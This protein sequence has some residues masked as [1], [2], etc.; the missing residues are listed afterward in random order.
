MNIGSVFSAIAIAGAVLLLGA[1]SS[2]NPTSF[3]STIG[4]ADASPAPA[5]G[6]GA[7]GLSLA[8]IGA[9]LGF[10]SRDLLDCPRAP[11]PYYGVSTFLPAPKIDRSMSLGQI[12]RLMKV[13]D[14]HMALG[15]TESHEVVFALMSVGTQKMPSGGVCAYPTRIAFTLALTARK[16]HVASDFARSEPCVYDAVLTH[17]ERHVALDDQLMRI[18]ANALRLAAPKRFA[19]LYGVWG[20][21]ENAA[22]LNLQRRLE[23]DD[24]DLRVE[25]ERKRVETQADEIDTQAERH[26]LVEACDGRLAKLYPGYM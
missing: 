16:I 10:K 3:G 13:D 24:E 1:C 8:A 9:A 26:H 11:A 19:N 18:A 6:G 12:G 7:R 2:R 5:S 25:I 23:A 14:R 15:A 4:N 17:E 22:R 20:E 21:S